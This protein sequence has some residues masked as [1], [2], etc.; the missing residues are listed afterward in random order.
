MKLFTFLFLIFTALWSA[1]IDTRLYESNNTIGYYEEV[2]KLIDKEV[3]Q[4]ESD[5]ERIATERMILEKLRGLLSSTSIIEPLPDALLTDVKNITAENYLTYLNGLTNTH[6]RI[7]TLKKEQ[8][9]M[10]SKRKYLKKSIND[11]ISENKKNL[12]LYQLEHAFYKLKG[13]NHTFSIKAYETLLKK[14]EAS[15]DQVLQHVI[16]NIPSLEEKLIG[17]STTLS[18]VIQKSVALK[19]T[20][21]RELMHNDIVSESLEKKLLANKTE[22]MNLFSTKMD[23]TL[24]LSLAYLQMEEKKKMLNLFN[25]SKKDLTIFTPE[26]KKYF[27]AK[28]TIIKTLFANEVGNISLA[29]SDVEEGAESFYEF[30]Y[31]QLTK[32]LFV[33]NEKAISSANILNIFAILIFGFF[34]AAFYRRRIL[35][36]SERWVKATPMTARLTANLGYYFIGFITFIIALN[37]IGLDLTSFSMFASALAIGVGF[38]LQTVV[39]NM[40]A[41]IIMMFERS[42]RI[43]D[44]IEIS[45]IL[46]GTVTDIRIRSTVIKTPDNIDVVVPNSSFIQNNVIN[47]TL[48]DKS[49][50]LHIPFGVA[51][52]TEVETVQHAILDELKQSELNFYKGTNK[53]KEPL[54]RMLAMGSSSVDYELL[55]WIEWGNKRKPAALISDF[56]ILIYKT[57]YKHNIEIPFPQLDLHVKQTELNKEAKNPQ[58]I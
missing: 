16:F 3:P 24:L 18:N 33:F 57:L 19:I 15:F 22:M 56:L 50:R 32:T 46:K 12:L 53:D 27:T 42:I 35:N 21:E 40:V 1:D 11:I 34:I 5:I 8:S 10:Q 49:R 9:I 2:S 37:S 48:D 36:W 30:T 54:V 38:G 13:K 25:A 44:F 55:V 43:G 20:K 23:H 6:I 58:I 29:L 14:G 39:S 26:L 41:G 51:Y 47:M 17:I 7:E 28:R 45:D 31:E 4:D 52:G